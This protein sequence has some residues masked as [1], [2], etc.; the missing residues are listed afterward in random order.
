MKL[1]VCFSG[2]VELDFDEVDFVETE[3]GKSVPEAVLHKYSHGEVIEKLK[4]Q[5]WC[6]DISEMIYVGDVS[7][8]DIYGYQIVD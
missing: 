5:E 8:D 2:W 6:L 4:G 7:W 3:T 1:S